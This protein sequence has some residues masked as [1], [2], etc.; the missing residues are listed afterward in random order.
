ML[1]YCHV[2]LRDLDTLIEAFL[3]VTPGQISSL[4][5]VGYF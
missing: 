2:A 1:Y 5:V 3:I 4:Q